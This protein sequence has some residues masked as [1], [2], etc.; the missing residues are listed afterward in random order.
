[1]CRAGIII[2]DPCPAVLPGWG[3]DIAFG[4]NLYPVAQMRCCP[5]GIS[6]NFL[7]P[8]VAVNIG[9]IHASNALFKTGFNLGLNIAG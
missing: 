5:Q 6:Q 2:F 7:S 1:M 3:N 4:Y 8:V 9:L